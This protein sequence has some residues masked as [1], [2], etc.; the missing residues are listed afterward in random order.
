MKRIFLLLTLFSTVSSLA[1]TPYKGTGGKVKDA[2]S[3]VYFSLRPTGIGHKSINDTFGL[4]SV[5]IKLTH[6][7]VSQLEI[8][9]I[10]PDGTTLSLYYYNQTGKNFD[11]TIFSDTGTININVAKASFRGNY[12]PYLSQ[13]KS[14]NNGQNPDTNWK[15][16]IV[17]KLTPAGRGTLNYW[18]LTFGNHPATDVKLDSSNLPILNINTRGNA[19]YEGYKNDVYCDVIDNGPGK[20]NYLKDSLKFRGYAGLDIR[21]ASSSGFPK[22]SYGLETRDSTWQP[23]NVALLGL[24]KDNDWA[25]EANYADKTL[26]NNYLAYTLSREFGQNGPRT[27]M[28]EVVLDG[29]YQGVYLL[30][31]KIKVTKARVPI[32]K[33]E[34]ADTTGDSLTGGYICKIDWIHGV[35]LGG[36][37][38]KYYA[39]CHPSNEQI[40]IQYDEPQTINTPQ[41]N[42]I[43]SYVD[44]FE[45]ALNGSS[46]QDPKKGWRKYADES[47][48]ID[49][50]LVNE[51]SK[52]VDGYRLS[53]YFYK[54]RNSINGGKIHMG[55]VWDYD[56][57]FSN[58]NYGDESNYSSWQYTYYCN[59]IPFW[60]QQFMKD[61][62]F[63]N[64]MKCRWT[65][66]RQVGFLR[67]SA[68]TGKID[69]M[70]S[71]LNEAQIRN[72]TQWNILGVYVWP[73]TCL[74]VS[75]TRELDTMKY[76]IKKRAAWLDKNI[77]G[78]CRI[79]YIPP[80]VSFISSDT[81]YLEV[82]NHYVDSGIVYN[83]N[84]DGKNCKIVISSNVDSTTLGNYQYWYDVY[85]QTGNKR[86]VCRVVI[87]ID[88][89]P[90]TISFTSGDTIPIEVYKQYTGKDVLI[91]DNYDTFPPY[92]MSGTFSF[93]NNIPTSLGLY[94]VQYN[95][96]DYSG[97]KS[98]ATRYVNVI[99]TIAPSIVLVG[100]NNVSILQN[101]T[102]TDSGYTVKDNYDT[103]VKV[104]TSGTFT[105]TKNTGI[106]S[107]K[108]SAKDHSG[109]TSNPVVRT[110][111]ISAF[112]GIENI[113]SGANNFLISPNP[114]YGKFIIQCIGD[115]EGTVHLSMYNTLGEIIP[116][117]NI[118]YSGKELHEINF[119]NNINAGIYYLK[120]QSGEK[121]EVKKIILLR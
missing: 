54:D 115:P 20:R 83:D 44:S 40:Y 1:G 35:Y 17:D 112:T 92:T 63:K 75:Y 74:P 61:S 76:W 99:D 3:G 45:D 48:F 120:I 11:S 38:S 28:C 100:M 47:S 53:T 43:H 121:A 93:K 58:A 96:K 97:N 70:A 12:K 5:T 95:A 102:Y 86:S 109:N 113:K 30:V 89:I 77:K 6:P 64:D 10:A 4:E 104:D 16:Y 37:Y 117:M 110:I 68:L 49:Y 24:P 94:S 78:T 59:L 66:L 52:N 62:T 73:N 71:Y 69:S 106:Y 8:W 41:Q 56:L 22:K 91:Q 26:M 23:Y 101:S 13:L 27:K 32:S 85:D 36:W 14:V 31:E 57:S 19:I 15:L 105:D 21:G 65:R 67:D 87:V 88:T 79:D 119:P 34:P 108:Y 116:G 46:F 18:Y 33:L 72:F 29:V 25:L 2:G 60:W 90:P 42:Y 9:L 39:A 103:L 81:A 111:D 118:Q 80:V 50:F 98:T 7:D 107:I 82:F 114:T 84:R 55:P 51:L